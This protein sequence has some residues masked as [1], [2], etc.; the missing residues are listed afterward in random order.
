MK[1]IKRITKNGNTVYISE[2]KDAY[3]IRVVFKDSLKKE[4][5]SKGTGNG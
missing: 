5:Q 3:I 2:T 4:K 1:E